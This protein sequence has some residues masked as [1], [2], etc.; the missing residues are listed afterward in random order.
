MSVTTFASQLK[1]LRTTAGFTQADLAQQVGCAI[2]TL[3]QIEHGKRRPSRQMAERL[4]QVLKIA[5]EARERFIQLG[6]Q[7]WPLRAQT[8]PYKGL[9]PFQHQDSDLF[10]GRELLLNDVL[11]RLRIIMDHSDLPRFLAIVGPSGSGKSSFV[12]AG[13]LPA[14]QDGALPGSEHWHIVSMTPGAHPLNTLRRMLGSSATSTRQTRVLIID[15]FEEVF[16]LCAD[17]TERAHFLGQIV[18]LVAAVH[19]ATWIMVTL[20]ADFYDRPLRYRMLGSLLRTNTELVLPLTPAEIERAIVGPTEVVGASVEPALVA[21]LIADVE[22]R[23]GALPLLQY[24]LTELFEYCEGQQ[25]TLHAYQRLGGVAGVVAQRADQLFGLLNLPEQFAL[26]QVF[27]RLIQPGE[28]GIRTRRRVTLDELESLPLATS[29]AVLIEQFTRHRLLTLDRDAISG[30]ITIELA[31]EMLIT[32]WQTLRDWLDHHEQALITHRQLA[33]AIHDWQRSG[34]EPS[35][36]ARGIRLAQFTELA[37]HAQISLNRVE[38]TF[39]MASSAASQ[40][41]IQEAQAQQQQ[42]QMHLQHSEALRLAAESHRLRLSHGSAELIGLL[43]LHSM[44]L[45]YTPQGDEV[46]TNALLLDFPMR[47]FHTRAKRIHS[48]AYAPDGSVIA[49]AGQDPCIQ[50]W[51]VATGAEFMQLLGHQGAVRILQYAADGSFLASLSDDNTVRIWDMPGGALRHQ[52]ELP[53]ATREEVTLALSPDGQCLLVGGEYPEA[54]IWDLKS[55]ELLHTLPIRTRLA[56]WLTFVSDHLHCL[57]VST[58]GIQIWDLVTGQEHVILEQ[59]PFGRAVLLQQAQPLLL[60]AATGTSLQIWNLTT[61]TQIVMADEHSEPIEALAAAHNGRMIATVSNDGTSRIWDAKTGEE[62][63]RF[64]AHGNL[65]WSVA[66][67]PNDD[68]LVTGGTDGV[69]CLWDVT[70]T[71]RQTAM[72]KHTAPIHAIAYLPDGKTILTAS[73]DRLL[74]AWDVEQRVEYRCYEG[75]VAP[76]IHGSMACS[77][78]GHF[79]AS[80][81]DDGNVYVWE[82]SSAACILR[83][84]AHATRIWSVAISTDQQWL[85][86]TG[87]DHIARIWEFPTGALVHTLKSHTDMVIG[88]AFSPDGRYGLTGSDDGTAR[89]WDVATGHEIQRFIDPRGPM[90]QVHFHPHGKQILTGSADGSM[91]L[92]DIASG[93]EV[94][95]FAGHQGYIYR[96]Q[97]SANGTLALSCAADRTIRLWDVASGKERRRLVGHT[98]VVFD[99]ALSP[100]NSQIVTCS[101]DRTIRFWQADDRAAATE[102]RA[103]ILRDFTLEERHM[104][105]IGRYLEQ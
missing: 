13:L 18:D 102:L 73:G 74:R 72:I 31:H 54:Y 33:Q 70:G 81:S 27:L 19:G 24:G 66:F 58:R 29:P 75:I 83:I 91:R 16:T 104:Y 99:A 42:L 82:T 65:I 49:T 59:T 35:Y 15:Q 37:D 68:L 101:Y 40:H 10:F 96:V 97:F 1:Q 57:I 56:R 26:Q 36:L 14:L 69:A 50:I 21:T 17:E 80:G 47:Y 52:F 9:L 53:P 64:V 103:R 45:Q 25:L 95:S 93:H 34:N 5:P 87:S 41:E 63:R 39:L 32:E 48:V 71:L 77:P 67:S 62:L 92:W 84:A 85:L 86:T 6:R 22:A 20:R 8:N 3:K 43:A 98:S 11:T 12:A 51:D 38:Q 76:M 23:P 79:V 100:D 30:G 88:A 44:E 78:D 105:G 2:I 90:M 28:I 89:V 61:E 46:L 4:A 7:R 94:R 55:G 60:A